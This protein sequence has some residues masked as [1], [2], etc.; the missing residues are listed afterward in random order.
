M[1]IISYNVNGIRAAINKDFLAWLQATNA[2]VVCLQEI[3]ATPDQIVDIILIEQ[4]GYKHYWYPAQKKGYSGT[5]IFCKTE[6]LQV[7]YGCGIEA[8]DFEGRIIR[9]DF[10]DFS[11]ISAYFPSGSSGEERQIFKYQFLDSFASYID[12]L[13]LEIP[14]LII[15][16]D[17]NICHQAIDIHNPKSNANSSGFLPEERAWM[18]NF[19]NSGFIDTFRHLNPHPHHYTWWSYRAGARN[20]N[21]GWR[22]DYH[23]VTNALAS[24]IKRVAILPEAKHSDHCPILLEL[25][26]EL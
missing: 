13:K 25:N 23:L 1:K 26:I 11:V 7:T 3:K 24:A 21:L 22:I 6:P 12:K 5:A 19:L 15:S 18:D 2:D 8:F 16:G 9:A 10:K 20:K 4:L 14:N 17:Y